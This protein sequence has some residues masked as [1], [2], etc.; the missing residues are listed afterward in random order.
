M[1]R[2]LLLLAAICGLGCGDEAAQFL[3]G[4]GSAGEGASGGGGG[5]LAATVAGAAGAPEPSSDVVSVG[6]GDFSD[7]EPPP[8]AGGEALPTIVRLTG[9]DTVTNGGT[10]LLH[11]ELS[12]PI[13]SPRFVVELLGASGYH[14]VTG[15]DP[16]GDG[17][18]DIAVQVAA[19]ATQTSFVFRVALIDEQGNVGPYQEVAVGLLMSGTGDVKVTLSFDRLH[20][21]D[22]HVVEP[23]GD[24]IFYDRRFSESGGQL[25]LDS[26]SNC[27][28]TGANA[29]NIFWPPGGAPAGDYR[30]SVQNYQQCSPGEIAFTVRI[31][32]DNVVNTYTGSFAEGTA[33][34]QPTASNVME[35]A[36]FRRGP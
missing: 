10:A 8:P 5:E 28:S 32:H 36:T 2:R 29:E 6:D 20:D 12:P 16:E 27:A 23:S 15:V 3:G 25:D 33:G 34:E 21:L 24:E 14:T 18:Y 7:G 30:V 35:I 19:E 13:P 4:G 17:V 1:T 11:V 22:L 26:G 31:E 9:P